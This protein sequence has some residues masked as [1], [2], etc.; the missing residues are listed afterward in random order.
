MTIFSL[1][2]HR[3]GGFYNMGSTSGVR[4]T[5]GPTE[6]DVGESQRVPGYPHSHL[7]GSSSPILSPPSSLH[8]CFFLLRTVSCFEFNVCGVALGSRGRA[9]GVPLKFSVCGW[10]V[11]CGR[12]L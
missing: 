5:G 12:G 1:S 7:R 4:A 2:S 11:H 8:S 3:G 6:A 9:L 10:G